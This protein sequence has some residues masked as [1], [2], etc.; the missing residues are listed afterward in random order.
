LNFTFEGLKAAA[1]SSTGWFSELRPQS[2]FDGSND[3][4]ARTQ[5]R[6]SGSGELD[7]DLNTPKASCDFRYIRETNSS[8][9]AGEFKADNLP[10]SQAFRHI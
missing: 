6:W 4:I 3:A 7:D 2:D 8:M 5:T 9:D 1:A 10:G